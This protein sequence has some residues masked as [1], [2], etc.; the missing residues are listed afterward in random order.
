MPAPRKE[1]ILQRLAD[2]R[3]RS[4]LA[5]I[6]ENL[7]AA[8]QPMAGPFGASGLDVLA[9]GVTGANKG[10]QSYEDMI[11]KQKAEE[12]NRRIKEAELRKMTAEAGDLERKAA[13]GGAFQGTSMDAQVAN[14][15]LDPSADPTSPNWQFAYQQYM[16][17]KVIFDEAT[18]KLISVAPQKVPYIEE[19]N[20]LASRQVGAGQEPYAAPQDAI[21]P[22]QES[23]QVSVEQVTEGA[24]TRK[25]RAQEDQSAKD[26][27]WQL[28]DQYE[29]ARATVSDYSAKL[30]QAQALLN[31]NQ[32]GVAD[33]AL[34]NTFQ[35]LVDEGA[36][37][38]DQDVTL[39][40]S[41]G[42]AFGSLQQTVNNLRTGEKLPPQVRQQMLEALAVMQSEFNKR[43]GSLAE[44]YRARAADFGLNPD[45]IAKPASGGGKPKKD[46][47][48]FDR[49]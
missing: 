6:S 47:S 17:P 22:A 19:R 34:I 31:S 21:P 49:R 20:A 23:P 1:G 11:A 2:P 48:K 30:S 25:A 35:K 16:A 37:V 8:G 38:R 32:S 39:L 7:I 14:I 10:L 40:S 18:G 9:A 42:G 15:L 44:D 5:G 41:T 12:F 27:T 4:M 24:E 13:G 43:S 33:I 28:R 45:Q 3:V 46:L 36:V 29:K 26:K